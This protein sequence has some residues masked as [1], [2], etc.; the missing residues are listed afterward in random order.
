MASPTILVVE[1]N[2][3]TNKMMRIT[4]QTEGYQALEALDGKTALKLT[5]EHEPDLIFVDLLLPDMDG[6]ELTRQLRRLQAGCDIPIIAVSGLQSKLGEARMLQNGFTNFLFKP[7]TPDSLLAS[8]Q[9]ALPPPGAVP[10]THVQGRSMLMVDDDLVQGKL[11]RLHFESQGYHVTFASDIETALQAAMREPPNVI[12]TDLIMPGMNGLDLCTQVRQIPSLTHVPIVLTS[13]TF[14]HVGPEEVKMARDAGANTFAPRTPTLQELGEAVASCLGQPPPHVSLDISKLK[15]GY[16]AGLLRQL[17]HQANLN[18]DLTDR[19]LLQSVQLSIHAAVAETFTTNPYYTDALNE[20]L[21]R[22]LDAC[23]VSVGAVYLLEPDLGL[24]LCSLLGFQGTAKPA[25][26]DFFGHADLLRS[27][28]NRGCLMHIPSPEVALDIGIDLLQR[29]Q[30]ARM[31]IIPMFSGSVPE[32]VLVISSSERNVEALSDSSAK[33]IATQMARTVTLARALTKVRVSEERYRGLVSA[34]SQIV[35]TMTAAGGVL[36]DSPTWRHYTGQTLEL[37]RREGWISAVHPDDLVAVS[38]AWQYALSLKMFFEKDCRL[39]AADGGYKIFQLRSAPIFDAGGGIHEWVGTCTDITVKKKAEEDRDRYFTQA[40]DLIGLIGVDGHFVRLNPA[41]EACLGFTLDELFTEPYMNLVHPEDVVRAQQEIQ[42]IS[43]GIETIFFEIRLRCKNGSYKTLQWNATPV[44]GQSSFY[45]YGRDITERKRA[46]EVRVRLASIVES[47]EDAI[48]SKTLEGIV[49]S[50]N[51]G[52]ERTF[53]YTADEVI[54]KP[55]GFL[56]PQDRVEEESQIIERVKQ[57]EH[58]THFETVRRRKDGKDINIALT[59]SPIEDGAGMIIGFSEIARDITEQKSLEAQL[60]QS[61]KME[62]VGQ[63]A[64][65]IAHDFNNL[66]TVINSYSAMVLGELDFSNPFARNGIEQIKE[67]GHRAASLTRQLLMFSRQQVLEPKVL[68][69]NEVVSNIGKL[70]RRLI[71]E[72]IT[73]VLCLHPALG[74]VKIDPG[75]ME[76]IIMNLAVNA[77]D[78]MPLGGQ[79][80]IETDNVELDNAYARTH[81]L[82]QPGPY[83]MLAVSDTGCGMDADTQARIFEPFFTTKGAGKR[84]RPG[85]GHR[86]RDCQTERRAHLGL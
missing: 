84:D 43:T 33:T 31:L 40:R 60:R 80:T 74:R 86:R 75:Q 71:G 24:V 25:A 12:V 2:I 70:L 38:R 46:E 22:L 85:P 28:L 62:G 5:K 19:C 73:Q 81:A 63:L 13:S 10:S 72:D 77:R 34:T 42:R 1:D 37:F 16:E 44:S 53:G 48:I 41:W 6:I 69:L 52:A 58:V 11:Q 15:K 79:L 18:Q 51:K 57:G 45:A 32:G 56:I 26:Q 61:Q 49:T 8:L 4:I 76:Q 17:E 78:A 7:V 27:V 50:W 9:H 59:I 68:D 83:V 39:R 65:G 55:I 66:L 82:V 47:S 36:E 29:A 3:I 64:G 23:G 20:S 35:W 14:A 67:A 54:G 21:A 30:L